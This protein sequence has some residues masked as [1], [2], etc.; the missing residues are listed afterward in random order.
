MSLHMAVPLRPNPRP[1]RRALQGHYIVAGGNAPGRLTRKPTD[2]GGVVET[3]VEAPSTVTTSLLRPFQG[4]AWWARPFPGALPP[5]T[6]SI[7]F[8]DS[9]N[10]HTPPCPARNVGH[11][12]PEPADHPLPPP[13]AAGGELDKLQ[14]IGY[15]A[16]V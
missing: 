9:Q 7:P 10:I 13:A 8:G 2:P 3:W 14:P 4:R 12:E 1:V 11:A 5:A 16:S 6:L 15:S